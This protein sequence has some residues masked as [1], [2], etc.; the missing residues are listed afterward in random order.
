M[1]NT[2]ASN[3]LCTDCVAGEY[4]T[5]HNA[6]TT[7]SACNT[8]ETTASVGST[9]ESECGKSRMDTFGRKACR[10]A[11][12]QPDVGNKGQGLRCCGVRGVTFPG[13]RADNSDRQ[14]G[15]G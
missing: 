5:A 4:K 15:W 9:L 10:R 8:D 11:M 7:C 6:D 14:T 1:D 13:A 3:P 2:D 12:A